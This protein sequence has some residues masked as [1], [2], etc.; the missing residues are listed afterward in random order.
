[1]RS[2]KVVLIGALPGE[3]SLLYVSPE[4]RRPVGALL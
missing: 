3:Q 2:E 4:V 1:M